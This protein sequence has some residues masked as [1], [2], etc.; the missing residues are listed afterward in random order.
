MLICAWASAYLEAE[1]Q[2]RTMLFAT[3]TVM[4]YILTAT[5]PLA[6]FP[7]SQAPNW[8]IGSKVYLGFMVAVTFLFVAIHYGLRW[9]TKKDAEVKAERGSDNDA[10]DR[11]ETVGG[12][13]ASPALAASEDKR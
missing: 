12:G 10:A 5:I 4:S 9:Q 11:P 8:R 7:A 1:P 6:A 2:V 13:E 3:G